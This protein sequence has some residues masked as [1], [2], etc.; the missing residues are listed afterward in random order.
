MKPLAD[1][2]DAFMEKYLAGQA[3]SLQEVQSLIRQGTLTAE[4]RPGRFAARPL[5]TRGS[6]RSWMP[7]WIIFPLPWMFP[8]IRGIH[9]DTGRGRRSARP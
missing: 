1:L 2:D 8:P 9:P 7:W 3:I 5:R 4:D 6:S